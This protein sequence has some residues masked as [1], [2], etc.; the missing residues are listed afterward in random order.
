M[1]HSVSQWL[2]VHFGIALIITSKDYALQLD[3]RSPK[4]SAV[5]NDNSEIEV[6][7]LLNDYKKKT[8]TARKKI[9]PVNYFIESE[10][11]DERKN[12]KPCLIYLWLR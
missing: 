12:F 2:I 9:S 8:A 5:A 10:S 3:E 11:D 4:Y 1:G 6:E 7:V